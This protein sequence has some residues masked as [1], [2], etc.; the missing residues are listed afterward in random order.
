MNKF[1]LALILLTLFLSISF[2]GKGIISN[3]NAPKCS[4]TVNDSI[5]LVDGDKYS[6]NEIKTWTKFTFHSG[7]KLKVKM[8][9][10]M[11]V[12]KGGSVSLINCSYIHLA[13][14]WKRQFK[15]FKNGDKIVFTSIKVK[16]LDGTIKSYK[17]MSIEVTK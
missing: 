16:E 11:I 8:L 14:N 15:Y 6:L 9:S 10:I 13:K 3:S 17:G 2:I 1:K 7:S 5:D 12:P 4:I